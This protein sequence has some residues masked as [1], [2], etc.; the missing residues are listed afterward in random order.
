MNSKIRVGSSHWP[1]Y[2]SETKAVHTCGVPEVPSTRGDTLQA[3]AR[4][5]L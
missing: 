3:D 5:A 2:L 1:P 4:G